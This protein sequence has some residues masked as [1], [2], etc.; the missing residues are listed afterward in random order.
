MCALYILQS[1][2]SGRFYI[3]STDDLQRRFSEHQRGHTPSTRGR[4]PWKIAYTEN[5]D[6]LL[7]AR[8]REGEIKRWKS[9]KM[10]QALIFGKVVRAGRPGRRALEFESPR[11]YHSVQIQ[12]CF[13]R[14]ATWPRFVPQPPVATLLP[15]NSTPRSAPPCR[16]HERHLAAA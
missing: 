10:V 1:E 6:L 13:A 12:M 7:Q 15:A 4:G 5:F 3:G 8:R 9:A 11:A 2:S 14:T 16:W